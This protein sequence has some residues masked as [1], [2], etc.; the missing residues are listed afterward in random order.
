MRS[1]SVAPSS[2]A[3]LKSSE[4]AGKRRK[5]VVDIIA[6]AGVSHFGSVNKAIRLAELARGADYLKAQA[7]DPE[8]LTTDPVIGVIPE[9]RSV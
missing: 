4:K 5:L 6:E 2:A 7:Y 9:C 8:K 1:A 3:T